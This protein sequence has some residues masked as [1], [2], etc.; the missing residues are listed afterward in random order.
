[1]P[2]SSS[3]MQRH[4]AQRDEKARA[5]TEH[6][7]GCLCGAVRFEAAG[8]PTDTAYC[9]CFFCRRQT[10]A[11]VVAFAGFG[12]DDAFRWVKGRPAMYKSSPTVR[13]KFCRRCGTPLTFEA[14]RYPGRIYIAVGAFDDPDRLP[15]EAHSHWS[16][17]IAW[18]DTADA[19]PRHSG[20]SVGL[21]PDG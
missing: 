2:K 18:F 14:D 16:Q 11:P 3:P 17:R 13:R 4:V 20:S 8:V 6:A 15:P 12:T 21:E 1:M 5:I 9:H 10:G 7:G 19:L